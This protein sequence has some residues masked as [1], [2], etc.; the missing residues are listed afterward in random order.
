MTVK[1]KERPRMLKGKTH[2]IEG[3][4][5][6]LYV[7][8]NSDGDGL[9]EAF[10]TSGKGGGCAAAQ[11][12]TVGRLISLVLRLGGSPDDLIKQLAGITCHQQKMAIGDNPAVKSCGD[13]I[14][15]VLRE[16]VKEKK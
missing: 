16:H 9:F 12:E 14:S 4:C 2:E 11:N 15:I 5:G 10:V 3:G 7:T 6:P 1:K 8:L 13:A